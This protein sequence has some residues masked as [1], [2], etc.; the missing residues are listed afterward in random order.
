ADTGVSVLLGNGDGTFQPPV[1]HAAGEGSIHVV[2]A[3]F[4]RDGN[5]D[6]AASTY[7]YTQDAVTVLLGNGD[8]T[9]RAGPTL[10]HESEGLAAGDVNGDGKP[11][12]LTNFGKTLHVF[13]GNGDGTFQKRLAYSTEG[14]VHGITLADFNG[15]GKVDVA[16]TALYTGTA[17]VLLGNGDGTFQPYTAYGTGNFPRGI[18]SSDVDNDGHPDLIIANSGGSSVSVLFGK[19]DGT[20]PDQT[21]YGV[22]ENPDEVAVSDVNGD[23]KLDIASVG[24]FSKTASVLINSGS[25]RFRTRPDLL[26][27]LYPTPAA[28]GDFNNDG[29]DDVIVGTYVDGATSSVTTFLSQGNGLLKR[30]TT[31]ITQYRPFLFVGDFNADGRLDALSVDLGNNGYTYALL[32]GN[33]D[34]TF[35]E[36]TSHPLD[37]A[38]EAGVA[39]LN[40]D[41]VTD[42][43]LIKTSVVEVLLGNGDG[44]FAAPSSFM[45][46]PAAGSPAIADFDRDGNLDLAFSGDNDVSILKGNGDGT[47][48]P[49]VVS[50][51]HQYFTTLKAGDLNGDGLPD[52]AGVGDGIA[53]VLLGNGD[54]SFQ[55]EVDYAVSSADNLAVGDFNRDGK[56]DLAVARIYDLGSVTLLLNNGDGTFRMGNDY[57]IGYAG[58][59]FYN[60]DLAL[61]D[62]NGDGFPDFARTE[63]HNYSSTLDFL[64]SAK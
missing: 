19:G 45:L 7:P 20:F 54:G 10:A 26:I 12:L 50:P 21:I 24:S 62:F 53:G 52:L 18:V 6:L 16:T 63:Q 37:Q 47:F 33:G 40:H 35:Q 34:G 27:G 1:T 55:R 14:I 46:G 36:M 51:S 15:D 5:P 60:T 43:I 13:L 3:D 61:G 39:D 57:F 29:R 2:V 17:S 41:E 38:Y 11:D 64:L 44:T 58:G 28:A 32:S 22:T 23:G 4:N 25:R 59:I 8:G 42:L 56:I 49:F 31:T 48:Q 9:F 30:R